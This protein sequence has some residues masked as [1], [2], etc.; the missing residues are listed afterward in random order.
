LSAASVR[1]IQGRHGASLAEN[2][3]R[4]NVYDNWSDGMSRSD[5]IDALVAKKSA[6]DVIAALAR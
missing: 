5:K 1:G 6:D 2:I 4:G 3:C